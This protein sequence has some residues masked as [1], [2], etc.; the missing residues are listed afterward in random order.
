MQNLKGTKSAPA[1]LEMRAH[2][3]VLILSWFCSL[4]YFSKMTVVLFLKVILNHKFLI[5]LKIF[6][7]KV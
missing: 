6:K 3:T 2:L 7:N 4:V 1:E 5:G